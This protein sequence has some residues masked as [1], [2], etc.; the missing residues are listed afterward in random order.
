MLLFKKKW[1]KHRNNTLN[2]PVYRFDTTIQRYIAT[3][4]DFIYLKKN[5]IHNARKMPRY[6]EIL[7]KNLDNSEKWVTF[8]SV[9]DDLGLFYPLVLA[10]NLKS[11]I[12]LCYIK[13]L[14]LQYMAKLSMSD[15]TETELIIDLQKGS[16]KAFNAIYE[17]YAR[18]LYAFCLKYT[19][20]RQNAEEIVEDT[21]V[22]VW[23]NRDSIK[24]EISLK[25]ILFLKT[26]HLLINAYRKVVNSPIY[27]DYMDYID[28]NGNSNSADSPM[29]YDEF[30][31]QVND[32][33]DQ[34]P[35][36]QQQI[37]RLSKFEQLANKDI[38]EQLNYSEQT[39]KNQLSIGLKQLRTLLK[40]KGIYLF[41][42]L[43]I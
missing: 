31:K 29:E 41:V 33:I 32:C 28:H 30:M 16:V 9:T 20:S 1:I 4:Y 36:A 15:K 38:A 10:S 37:I 34:L 8:A 42:L 17:L 43:L 3:A 21:F 35:K 23:N 5:S 22:W 12:G 7:L 40:R 26:K 11:I 24:Q 25:P 27:E 6:E 13:C 2:L 39:V 14:H 18:R 19:K